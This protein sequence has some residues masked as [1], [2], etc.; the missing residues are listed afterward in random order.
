MID[1]DSDQNNADR[2]EEDAMMECPL[3]EPFSG[4]NEQTDLKEKEWAEISEDEGDIDQRL[5]EQRGI[6][7]DRDDSSIE[8]EI[9]SKKDLE[10]LLDKIRKR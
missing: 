2:D 9:P 3:E 4:F 10:E 5:K 6:P 7:L 1:P 8:K